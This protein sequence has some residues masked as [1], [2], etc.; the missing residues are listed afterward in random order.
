MAV[1]SFSSS[2]TKD[3]QSCYATAARH[4][5]E[6]EKELGRKFSI[7]PNDSDLVYLTSYFIGQNLAVPTIRNYLAGIRYYLLSLGINAPP[8]FPPLA[9]QLLVGKNF[10]FTE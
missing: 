3:T 5:M 10:N 9:E 2:V 8:K 4:Y 7:P 6:A 1:K